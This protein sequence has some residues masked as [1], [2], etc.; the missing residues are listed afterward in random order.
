MFAGVDACKG[1]WIVAKSA[2]WPNREIPVLAVCPD[3]RTVLALTADCRRVAVDIPI[4]LPS[5]QNLRACDLEAKKLLSGH[6]TSALFYAP[7]REA[8]N[9]ESPREFQRLHRK[10]RGTG[11][12]LPVWGFLPKVKEASSAM[13]PAL[14]ERIIEFHPELTWFRVAGENLESKHTAE[15][16]A[17]RKRLLRKLVPDL[18]RILRWKDYLGR[19]AAHDDLLDALIG[20]GVAKASLHG[21]PYRLPAGK[22]ETDRASLRMEIWY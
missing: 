14:Q 11:A 3:F 5:R 8:L 18:E 10:L 17:E 4:G 12:G 21:S 15:G 9:A 19:A 20:I 2:S 7:P 1:G 6:N 22:T 13:T 16:I